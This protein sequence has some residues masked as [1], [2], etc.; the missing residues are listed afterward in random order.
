M[1]LTIFTLITL[2]LAIPAHAGNRIPGTNCLAFKDNT[3]FHA[4][5]S[6][7][8]VHARSAA[9]M[10]RMQPAARDL[11]P[12]FGPSY[13]EQPAPYGIPI[14][15]VA[16]PRQGTVLRLCRRERP[17]AIRSGP[18]PRSRAGSP[19]GDRHT[20]VVDRDTCRLYETWATRK[21]GSNWRAG[22]GAT[23]NLNTTRCARTAGLRPTPRACRSSRGLLRF[24]EVQARRRPRDPLHHRL[25]DRSYLWPAR[26][27]AGAV[28]DRP[29]RRWARASG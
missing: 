2:A 27:Q 14:T 28:N 25:T 5:I 4:D 17:S 18:T 6:Q 19:T 20:V 29:I 8:P 26:H 7:L 12:D 24:D 15:V 16:A 22:S 10:A 11:H 1:R 3:Y 9:W 13:G 23:W 21:S